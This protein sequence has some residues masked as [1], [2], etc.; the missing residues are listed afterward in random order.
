MP[1][2][3]ILATALPLLLIMDPLGNVA[4]FLGILSDFPAKRQRQIIL[5]EML[6]ALVF[7]VIFLYAGDS[8]LKILDIDQHAI[9]IAGGLILFLISMKM[10]FPQIEQN[11]TGLPTVEPFI[12]PIAIPMVAGPSLIASI[13]LFSHQIQNHW[14]MLA[15]IGAAW[16][17][18]TMTVYFAPSL[19]RILREKGLMAC[20]RLMGLILILISTQM[21]LD[22]IQKFILELK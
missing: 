8:L 17:L 7:M 3:L 15:S 20:E 2:E 22:G 10:I 19:K 4:I 16:G 9:R 5:R 14:I 21:L 1:F 12:V 11:N 6:F 18:T 13:T